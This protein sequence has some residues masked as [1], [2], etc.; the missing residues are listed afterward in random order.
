MVTTCLAENRFHG[1]NTDTWEA[2]G[3]SAA[4]RFRYFYGEEELREWMPT[5]ERLAGEADQVHV[6]SNNCYRDYAARNALQMAE[7]LGAK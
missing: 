7:L 6:L 4:E 5:V 3:L 2:R 1:R